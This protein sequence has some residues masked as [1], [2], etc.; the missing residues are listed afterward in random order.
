MTCYFPCE[1][2]YILLLKGD[3]YMSKKILLYLE[4]AI[5]TA[6][7]FV[8]SCIPIQLFNNALDL[9]LGFIPIAILSI[10]RGILP[11]FCAGALW[12]I[13]SIL[14]GKAYFL[15]TT[16]IL[17][18]YPIAFASGSLLGILSLKIKTKSYPIFWIILAAFV[19][20]VARWSWHFIAGIIFWGNYAPKEWNPCIYSF[21]MN[22][23]SCLINATMLSIILIILVKKSKFILEPTQ[24]I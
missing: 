17:I 6:M 21:I 12:G 3:F 22:G 18:E 5:I 2:N 8:L 23:T 4:I 11:G 19:G 9:S 7:S 1:R 14:V 16:Q 20:S 13:L 24:N 15:T 10:R